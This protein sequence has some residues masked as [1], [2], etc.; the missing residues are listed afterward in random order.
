[1]L[2]RCLPFLS[3][4]ELELDDLLDEEDW[5]LLSLLHE[6]AGHARADDDADLPIS[7]KIGA[8]G[9]TVVFA[10]APYAPWL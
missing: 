2:F 1:M 3:L 7:C 10:S 6:R 8:L 4:L 5:S 9:L